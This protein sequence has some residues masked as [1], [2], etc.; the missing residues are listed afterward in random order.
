MREIF[1]GLGK[2]GH[3]SRVVGRKFDG[4]GCAPGRDEPEYHF[5]QYSSGGWPDNHRRRAAGD[6]AGTGMDF[7]P[8]GGI[9]NASELFTGF[10]NDELGTHREPPITLKKLNFIQK[11]QPT[12]SSRNRRK[13][14]R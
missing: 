8:A 14:Y 6:H 5:L 12:G 10:I 13:G 9:E 1:L 7:V 11:P 4:G 3:W 2:R